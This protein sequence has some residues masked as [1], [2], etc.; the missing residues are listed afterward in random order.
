MNPSSV[1][2]CNYKSKNQAVYKLSSGL[3]RQAAEKVTKL[4][5]SL[6]SFK[7]VRYVSI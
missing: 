4:S 6:P 3:L 5:K 2:L 7:D 1:H